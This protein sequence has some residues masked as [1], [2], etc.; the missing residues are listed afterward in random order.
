MQKDNFLNLELQWFTDIVIT[1]LKLYFNQEC[2]YQ[3]IR[4]IQ[5]PP[6]DETSSY[7]RFLQNHKMTF[8]DR[9]LSLLAW[10]PFLRPQ[11]LDCFQVKNNHTGQRFVEFGCEDNETTGGVRPT[12]ATA[13]FILAGDD[14]DERMRLGAYFTKH[15]F[16]SSQDFLK[17]REN[18]IDSFANWLIQPSQELLES[19]FFH[20]VYIPDF[21]SSFPA[22]IVSTERSWDELVLDEATIKQVNE[23]KLWVKHGERIRKEWELEGK[24]KHGYRA[25]FYGPSG[26]GKTFTVMLLGKEV[27]KPVFCIDL[28]MVISKYIGETEKNLAKIFDFAENREWILFFDEAD[29][30]FGKRTNVKDAH[31]RYA[32]QEVAYLLQRVENY[33]GLVILSTNFKANIDEAFA[34]RFQIMVNFPMPDASMRET[35]WKNTFSRK[36]TFEK[37]VNLREISETYELSGGSILNVVQY[38]SLMAMDRNEHIIRKNDI[39]EGIKKEY[40]KVGKTIKW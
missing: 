36:C 28:S 6:M 8:P 19:I 2:E 35:L 32:N 29:A 18:T 38:C 27:N 21:S 33:R 20:R 4:Q 17:K 23:I 40:T 10:I 34:R 30:L 9:V 14:V 1:R 39:I 15:P 22:T 31:D 12:L 24:I 37:G 11:I 3:D 7:C 16:F 26:S 5:L 13:L 25:L